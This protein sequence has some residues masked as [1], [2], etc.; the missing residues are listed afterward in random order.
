MYQQNCSR[1]ANKDTNCSDKVLFIRSFFVDKTH[2]KFYQ[3]WIILEN[4]FFKTT[5]NGAGIAFFRSAL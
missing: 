1:F 3:N 5:I 4:F 2:I